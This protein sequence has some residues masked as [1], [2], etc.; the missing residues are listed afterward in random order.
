MTDESLVDRLT[1]LGKQ[2]NQ[3]QSQAVKVAKTDDKAL[4]D[5]TIDAFVIT[6]ID[7]QYSTVMARRCLMSIAD[8]GSNIR[9]FIFPAATPKDYSIKLTQVFNGIE[10]AYTWPV[11]SDEDG[12]CEITGLYKR[13]YKASNVRNI[14]A[15]ATSH[16]VLWDLCVRMDKPI[17]VLEHDAIFR[18]RFSYSD[19]FAHNHS[20][21]KG[22]VCGLNNPIGATRKASTFYNEVIRHGHQG[23]YPCPVVDGINEKPLPQ[24]LAGNSA[25]VIKPFA[26]KQLLDKVLE[27]GIWPNDALM[28]KQL[29]PWLSVSLPFYTEVKQNKS[30]TTG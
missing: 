13:A 24:G 1:S 16:I 5:K 26:A 12:Y 8:T 19:L 20:F 7:D 28:C 10:P 4:R 27:I 29:F 25:Y 23:V 11:S 15:C 21:D 18:V 9:P 30:T 22:G 3:A 6:L 2:L 17:M 14:I